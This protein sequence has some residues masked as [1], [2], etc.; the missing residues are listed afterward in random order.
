MRLKTKPIDL[1]LLDLS[2]PELDGLEVLNIL[3]EDKP[4]KYVPV[5]VVTSKTEDRYRALEI[6]AEDFLSKPIDVIELKLKVNNLLKLKK[7]FKIGNFNQKFFNEKLEEEIAKKEKQLREFALVEQELQFAR[8]IQ[9]R[10]IPKSYPKNSRLEV[11]GKYISASQVG[12]DYLDVF[13][14]DSGEYTVFIMADVSGHG[15]ASALGSM[16]FRLFS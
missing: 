2:M 5:I 10:L 8:E 16:Q 3:K 9:Q 12:G 6:G 7:G 15:F 1:I 11:F 13:S 4:L 14:T